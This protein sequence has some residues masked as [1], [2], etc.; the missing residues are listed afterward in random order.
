MISSHSG[1]EEW[2]A[3]RISLLDLADH[4]S[5]LNLLKN[6][7]SELAMFLQLVNQFEGSSG[8]NTDK[9][10]EDFP[11]AVLVHCQGKIVYA[12][13][14]AIQLTG[15]ED[16]GLLIGADVFSFIPDE[17][18]PELFERMKAVLM[19]GASFE[20][21]KQKI[22]LPS[23]MEKRVVF[24]GMPILFEGNPAIQLWIFDLDREKISIHSRIRQLELLQGITEISLSL[25]GHGEVNEIILKT[26]RQILT[27]F[28]ADRVYLF[29]NYP[30]QNGK[31][32][33][34]QKYE[35]VKNAVSEQ[36][37]NPDLEVGSFE[38]L[39]F[40]RWESVLAKGDCIHG[41]VG[42]L[43]ESE[44]PLL[45]AQE[46]ASVLV[47][48]VL[49]GDRF[50]GFIGLDDCQRN[51]IWDI[52]EIS[53]LQSLG[54]AIGSFFSRQE[55][56]ERTRRSELA[57]Q[58]AQQIGKLGSFVYHIESGEWLFSATFRDMFRS[59]TSTQK[60]FNKLTELPIDNEGMFA[61]RRKW[62]SLISEPSLSRAEGEIEILEPG[63]TG[64][65]YSYLFETELREGQLVAMHGAI[66][67]ITERVNAIQDIF[68]SRAKLTNTQRIGR[69][70]SWEYDFVHNKIWFSDIVYEFIG[71]NTT[72][73][74]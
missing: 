22:I 23:G 8:G 19:T 58:K 67:D 66:Q 40:E 7:R 16:K 43:P 2:I 31:I 28:D 24:S 62:H 10:F 20:P 6:D 36:I 68:E 33:S 13:Q 63:K 48:P 73:I 21:R 5:Y 61:L 42:D 57:L 64:K 53:S 50:W 12:N 34:G 39:G 4:G 60:G 56:S 51:R 1:I 32:F 18:K 55:A 74:S 44:Q 71:R 65:Y 52:S 46:I 29:Q 59:L 69:I 47:A 70:G 54:L 41:P 15:L 37:E 27:L 17:D 11:M 30:D 72:S 38:D 26:F 35:L 14:T 3:R 49:V 45:L 9:E 25:V